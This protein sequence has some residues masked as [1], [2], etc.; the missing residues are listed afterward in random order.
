MSET[1]KYERESEQVRDVEQRGLGTG[2]EEVERKSVAYIINIII[3]L[4]NNFNKGLLRRHVIIN[5]TNI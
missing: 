4:S 1:E 2:N 5:N 3:Y